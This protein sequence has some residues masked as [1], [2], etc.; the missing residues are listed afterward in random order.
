M[1]VVLLLLALW[2]VL[3]PALVVSAALAGS[4]VLA[5]RQARRLGALEGARS[6]RAGYTAPVSSTGWV[7]DQLEGVGSDPARLIA[8]SRVRARLAHRGSPHA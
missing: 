4:S 7:R 3:T 6:L 8:R 5:H 1:S 2:I